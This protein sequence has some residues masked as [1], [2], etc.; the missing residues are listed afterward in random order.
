MNAACARNANP[1]RWV[2]ISFTAIPVQ[3]RAWYVYTDDQTT[4]VESAPVVGALTQ[5]LIDEAGDVIGFRVQMACQLENSG[6]IASVHEVSVIT[7]F[8]YVGCYEGSAPSR[9]DLASAL[10]GGRTRYEEDMSEM[11]AAQEAR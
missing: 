5:H 8:Q 4:D 9:E 7:G 3:M 6:E 11:Q 10:S 2:N 1:A